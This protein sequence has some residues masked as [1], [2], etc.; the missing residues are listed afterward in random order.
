MFMAHIGKYPY[1]NAWYMDSSTTNHMTNQ[2]DWFAS[3]DDIP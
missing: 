3:F 1:N 2:L